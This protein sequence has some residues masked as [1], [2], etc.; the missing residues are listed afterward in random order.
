MGADGAETAQCLAKRCSSSADCESDYHICDDNKC[1][2]LATHFDPHTAE[3][4]KFGSTGG[5]SSSVNTT[6]TLNDGG[7]TSSTDAGS[8]SNKGFGSILK[9]LMNNSDKL[10]YVIIVLAVLT[11]ILF[12]L[13]VMSVRKCFLGYCWTAHKKE[14]E[15]NNKSAPKSGYFNKNSINNKSFRQKNGETDEDVGD[16]DDTAADRSN[17]VTNNTADKSRGALLINGNRRSASG[18]GGN[19]NGAGELG[20][21]EKNR[22]VK[23]DTRRPARGA[24]DDDDEDRR[25][26]YEQADSADAHYQPF[27]QQL[28]NRPLS[29]SNS[30]AV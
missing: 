15:P 1:I 23:V 3:C 11:I 18:G 14:Y 5:K 16:N 4:Y 30:T 25:Q 19:D 22:Y 17:L 20:G 6:T 28:L 26:S 10:W 21:T 12:V 24:A 9:D 7:G 2:C 27:H 8:D 13:I 29:T